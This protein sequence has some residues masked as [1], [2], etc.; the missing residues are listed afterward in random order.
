MIFREKY[1]RYSSSSFIKNLLYSVSGN[2]LVLGIGF[3]ITPIVAKIYGPSVYGDFALFTAICGFIIPYSALQLPAGYVAAKNRAEFFVLIRISFYSLF[4]ITTITFIVV[5]I[6]Q[7]I[8]A[9][10]VKYYFFMIPAYVFLGGMF[11]IFRGWN[12]KIQEFK[13]SAK[14]KIYATAFGKSTTLFYGI[15]YPFSA[16]GLVLGSLVTFLIES[17]G[18]IT[19]RVI[20][21]GKLLIRNK[22]GKTIYLEVLKKY[23]QYPTFVAFSSIVNAVSTQLPIYFLAAYYSSDKVGLFSLSLSLIQIPINLI[24]TSIASVFLPKIA[25]VLR[26]KEE[27]NRIVKSLYNKLFYPSMAG[28]VLLAAVFYLLLTPLLGIEWESA[29]TLSSFM[30]VSFA[31]GIVSL[32]LSVIF[33]LIDFE[34]ANFQISLVGIFVKTGGLIVGI[35][36]VNFQFTVFLYLLIVMLE[37]AFK[38]LV[39]F[40]ELQLSNL[41]V[42]RDTVIAIIVYF[43]S[44]YVVFFV[45]K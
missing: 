34:K 26:Q 44:Y 10:D 11:G 7:F 1:A 6:Y 40:R 18:I 22:Y 38:V 35:L 27:R 39:L 25:G 16:T 33:R 31:F 5:I 23:K 2:S 4:L 8:F 20:I 37:N 14:A 19:K 45:I 42:I 24:G 29:S 13:S 17:A 30:V 28:L 21:E 12:I 43:T 3:I 32:P 41:T 36:L 15:A 9:T